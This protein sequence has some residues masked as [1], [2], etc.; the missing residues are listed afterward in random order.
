MDPTWT[1][2]R[3]QTGRPDDAKRID[4]QEVMRASMLEQLSTN[5]LQYYNLCIIYVT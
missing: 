4:T 1:D 2:G 3:G 5:V